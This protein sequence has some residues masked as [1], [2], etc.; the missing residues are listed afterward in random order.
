[1]RFFFNP[2]RLIA[3]EATGQ[4]PRLL[5]ACD[6]SSHH[7]RIY[8]QGDRMGSRLKWLT[9]ALCGFASTAGA[10]QDLTFG[11]WAVG[12]P[13]P[14][15]LLAVHSTLL[16]T[17][18]ILV[19][20]GSSYNCAFAWGHE[21]A[22]LYDIATGTWGAALTTPA[23]Y[24]TD[25]DGFCSGHA[26]DDTGAVVF[27]GGLLGYGNL[28]GHGIA[29]SARF[30]PST[31]HFTALTGGTDHWYPTLLAG[32]GH[33]FDF[34]GTN[35]QPNPTPAGEHIERLAYG[36]NAWVSTGVTMKTKA[37]Y[38]RVSLLP[39]GKLFVASPADA[40]RKNYLFDPAT[41]GVLPAGSDLVP[42]SEPGFTHCCESWKGT[43]VL[44]PLVPTSG[45]YPS[46][47]FALINGIKAWVKD[48]GGAT[49]TWAQLGT[50]APELGSPSPERHFANATFLPTGQVAVTGGVR[51]DELDSSK[52]G[53]AEIYDPE[54]DHWLVTSEA[55]IARNYHGVALLLPDGRIWTGSGSQN[56]CGSQCGGGCNGE[57]TE[58]GVEIFTPWY[59]GRPD[60]PQVTSC[61][62]NVVPDGRQFDVSIGGSQG[63]AVG[64]VLLL[65]AGSV[66]HSYDGDQRVIQLE[67]VSSDASKVTVKG[68]YNSNAAPPGDYMLFALHQISTTGMKRWVPST[69]CWTRLT[70]PRKLE[71]A[72]IWRYTNTPCNG[73]SCPGWEKLDNNPKTMA[74]S[75]A[76]GHHEQ[77]FYQLHNDGMIWRY[78][79]TPCTNDACPGW[80]R[81][82]NN[83][84]AAAISSAGSQLYQLHNDGMIWRYTGLPCNGDSCPGWQRLDNN[85]KTAAIAS[86]GNQLYQLHN[87]GMIWKYTNTPCNGDSCPGWQRLDNN[88]KTAAIAAS[89]GHMG[90][91]L[92]QLHN[93]GMIWMYTGTACN[94]DS[95]TGWQRL[96]K[97]SKTVAIA[98]A[99]DQLYQLHN[100]GWIWKYTGTPC[101]GDDC[102]GW[103]RL[104]NN[105][106]TVALA[107]TGGSLYQ[108]H[109]D[110]RIWRYTGTPCSGDNC[111]G[112]QAL[113]NNPKTA[114]IAA[115]DP[116]TMGSSDPVYQLHSDPLYQLHNDGWI[117]RYI[118]LECSGDSCPG[119]ERLDNNPKTVEI[120]SAGKQIF[121]RHNDGKIWRYTGKRCD[122]DS[123]PGWQQLDNNP[124]T[125]TIAVGG[126]MLYQLHNDGKIWRY[127]G[128]PCSGTS[129]P[130]WQRLDSNPK[131][132]AIAATPGSLYQL[133]NDGKIWRY[134]GKPCSGS[135]CPGWR[136]LDNNPKA[137]AIAAAGNQ[138]FELHNDGRIWRHT[139]TPCSGTS[140]PGWQPLDNNPH[141]TAIAA[142]ADQLYQ[143]HD[144]G[145]IW[146]YLGKP[147][148]GDSCT[149]WER[150]DNNPNTRE[151]AVGGSHLYQRHS[152]GRIWRYVGPKCSDSADSCP[153]WRQLDNNPKTTRISAA[154]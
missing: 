84:K 83:N 78:T 145:T 137:K 44:L 75:A 130:G 23:P 14:G 53:Q 8:Q 151:I 113:D 140:C 50:R 62:S 15:H 17:N 43:G 79:G 4:R 56:H 34:P 142:G 72:P 148:S 102:T 147:C 71:G 120:V 58:E 32:P 60:R 48:L 118:G 90:S 132:I 27:E 61:P 96:D 100:D 55:S 33:I 95:C 124:K 11:T 54:T 22:R 131:S 107:A 73:N 128:K 65:R 12:T 94:G 25:K 88:S 24:A 123:C 31:G 101:N 143:L 2:D 135:S 133:H 114:A 115:G 150:L 97:N 80:Q 104:D 74:I 47:R 7:P 18:K 39:N 26:H 69:A 111:P 153:G 30:D 28:N 122:G 127:T 5:T 116:A 91:H 117:W 10:D 86:A 152:D 126:I 1:L 20:G 13:A 108:M 59:Y 82:D 67:V 35:T 106:K 103:Q 70:G 51:A 144:D 16:R 92:Y 45:A 105:S 136:M 42:E 125:K 121:Q 38:P 57:N 52:V 21:E 141:T 49:P 109:N 99:E 138:L 66:T 134:T 87:D 81:L 6:R 64:R 98:A 29:N 154:Q 63:T 129:C 76:G 40:D 93:D 112:W 85:S 146:R 119:W 3:V 41:N 9:I 68:P 19:V 89:F 110:G 139:G 36:S 37:T 46:M 77:Q 149:S